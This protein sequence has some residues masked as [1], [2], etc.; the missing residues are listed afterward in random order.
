MNICNYLPWTAAEA[1]LLIALK[2]EIDTFLEIRG[3]KGN[4]NLRKLKVE[5]SAEVEDQS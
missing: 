5:K 3:S 4:M 2:F 1:E